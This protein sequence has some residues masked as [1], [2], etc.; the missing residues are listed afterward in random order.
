MAKQGCLVL[1]CLLLANRMATAADPAL[2]KAM[3]LAKKAGGQIRADSVTGD[4]EHVFLDDAKATDADVVA[5]VDLLKKTKPESKANIQQVFLGPEHTDKAVQKLA[6]I[7]TIRF[8]CLRRTKVTDKG[9]AALKGL[10]KL[11]TLRATEIGITDEGLK[12]LG[13]MKELQQIFL[14]DTKI[15]DAGLK[16]LQKLRLVTLSV[17]RTK[18]TEVGAQSFK[19]VKVER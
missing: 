12:H 11:A 18:V 19:G 13:E 3:E 7:K 4:I 6:E 9:L 2:E 15:T 5:I 10:P 14:D 17:K 8:V 1:V 16:H